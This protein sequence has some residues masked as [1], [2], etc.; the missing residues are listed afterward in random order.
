MQKIFRPY[1]QIY[2]ISLSKDATISYAR[3]VIAEA[4]SLMVGSREL[5]YDDPT[6]QSCSFQLD[7]P[8]QMNNRIK[9]EKYKNEK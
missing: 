1:L 2:S 6:Y 5:R 7:I 4:A 8:S 3:T 9:Y